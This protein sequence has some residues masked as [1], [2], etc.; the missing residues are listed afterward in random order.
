MHMD[1]PWRLVWTHW[2]P[3]AIADAKLYVT[4]A[5]ADCCAVD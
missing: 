4:A 1:A 5:T 3:Q 2:I